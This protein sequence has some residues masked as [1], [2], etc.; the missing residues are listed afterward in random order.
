M[1]YQQAL[2]EGWKMG[3]SKAKGKPFL[4]MIC[5]T[6][7]SVH[8]INPKLVYEG[9]VKQGIDGNALVNLAHTDPVTLGDLMFV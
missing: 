8:A 6:L 5:H 9:A 7:A 2:K 3:A 4:A 1:T